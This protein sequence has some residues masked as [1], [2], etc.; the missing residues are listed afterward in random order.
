MS[1]TAEQHTEQSTSAS[2][3][4]VGEE[5]YAKAAKCIV[6]MFNGTK[7]GHLTSER[8]EH[9]SFHSNERIA[10]TLDDNDERTEAT[11]VSIIED[12]SSWIGVSMSFDP[13]VE[14]GFDSA[15]KEMRAGWAFDIGARLQDDLRLEAATTLQSPLVDDDPE[16]GGQMWVNHVYRLGQLSSGIA[17]DAEDSQGSAPN[18][19]TLVDLYAECAQIVLRFWP[20]I[21]QLAHVLAKGDP[22]SGDPALPFIER[23]FN[24]RFTEGV[25]E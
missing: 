4:T 3:L 19:W 2:N 13:D 15:T 10:L 20:E 6:S 24:K 16:C 12:V 7:N 5:S 9:H 22:N 8:G 25:A 23:V 14:E 17:P 1:N 21:E 18:F 11:R